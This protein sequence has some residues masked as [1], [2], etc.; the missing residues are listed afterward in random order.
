MK[1]AVLERIVYVYKEAQCPRRVEFETENT[2]REGLYQAVRLVDSHV[3]GYRDDDPLSG[4]F[5]WH[6]GASTSAHGRLLVFNGQSHY[7][8]AHSRVAEK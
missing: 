4:H 1:F 6:T 7:V 5:S 3:A 8:L 2:S